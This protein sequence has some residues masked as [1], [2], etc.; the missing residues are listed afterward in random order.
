MDMKELRAK[1]PAELADLRTELREECFNLR[2]QMGVEN[3]AKTHEFPRIRK[4]IARIET[5]LVEQQR[6]DV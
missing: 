6:G 1:T 2:M 3:Q 4:D 5:L